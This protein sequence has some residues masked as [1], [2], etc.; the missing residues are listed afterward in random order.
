MH[1]HRTT[2]WKACP[3]IIATLIAL[4]YII[5]YCGIINKVKKV[6]F[7]MMMAYMDTLECFSVNSRT[8]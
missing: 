3:L 7:R 1:V 2:A 4:G 8:A 6:S 5:Q